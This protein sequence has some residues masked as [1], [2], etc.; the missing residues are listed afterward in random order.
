MRRLAALIIGVAT[1]QPDIDAACRRRTY[2]DR[3]VVML[4]AFEQMNKNI[5]V[6]A[7]VAS[8]AKKLGRT[9][10][11]P[12]Y[13]RSRVA[14]PFAAPAETGLALDDVNQNDAFL[15]TKCET[16]S[17]GVEEQPCVQDA[18]GSDDDDCEDDEDWSY[19]TKEGDVYKCDHVAKKPEKR[20]G[21]VGND[22][23]VASEACPKTCGTC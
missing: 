6:V 10:V 22:G 20:C 11:E 18:R 13:C 19:T 15:R 7:E 21:R 12:L 3:Y 5:G 17:C 2:P 14:P 23:V 1:A 16:T 8:W 9:F 4:S